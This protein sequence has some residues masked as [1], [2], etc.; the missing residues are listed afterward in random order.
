MFYFSDNSGVWRVEW[1]RIELLRWNGFPNPNLPA[2]GLLIAHLNDIFRFSTTV[3]AGFPS[4][5][6]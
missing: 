3:Y 6:L 5:H 4:I 2:M 1:P